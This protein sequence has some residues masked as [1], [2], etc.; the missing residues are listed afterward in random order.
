MA[1]KKTKAKRKQRAIRKQGRRK[2]TR[3]SRSDRSRKSS[4]LE[5]REKV[6]AAVAAVR[7]AEARGEKLSVSQ[8]ARQEGTTVAAIK[9]FPQLLKR[10]QPGRPLQVTKNDTYS[11][12]VNILIPLRLHDGDV[13]TVKV[14]GYKEAQLA[15]SYA[16]TVQRVLQG[17]LPPSALDE[18]RGVSL[19]REKQPLLTDYAAIKRLAD[20]GITVVE[21]YGKGGGAR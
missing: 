16:T 15:S 5:V 17:K 21:F 10:T 9:R 2:P 6:F 8:A 12:T 4:S 13:R 1:D 7:R 18:F 14:R 3:I 19:G 11:R 20:A